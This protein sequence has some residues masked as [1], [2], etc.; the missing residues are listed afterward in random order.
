MVGSADLPHRQPLDAACIV[1]QSWYKEDL[2]GS[3]HRLGI[4]AHI[5][6][7]EPRRA[8]IANHQRFQTTS[9]LSTPRPCT[10][11]STASE[12]R[13]LCLVIDPL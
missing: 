9:C 2:H 8:L 3:V 1:A 12:S 4:R 10:G 7:A 11:C 6:T 13:L 5:A